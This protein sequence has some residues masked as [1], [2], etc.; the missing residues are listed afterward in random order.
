MTTAIDA[1]SVA[2]LTQWFSPG[3]PLGAFAYS[4]GL[5]TAIADGR[6]RDAASVEDWLTDVIAH[7]TGRADAILLR[8]AFAAPDRAA[9]E[10]IDAIA[11]AY[12]VSAERVQETVLQGAAF[13]ATT[14]AIWGDD[15]PAFTLPVAVAVAARAQ[16]LPLDLTVAMYL[17]AFAANLVSAAVRLIPLGQTEGQLVL[18]NLIAVCRDT[19]E[20]T[21]GLTLDDLASHCF[22]SDIAAMRHETLKHRIFRS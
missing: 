17:Q 7:G 15:T 8:A 18:R 13:A 10:M 5:E 4:H 16:N 14:A 12:A 3:Y 9:H 19:A 11:R 6:L 22:G 21:R 2:V 20:A 1:H